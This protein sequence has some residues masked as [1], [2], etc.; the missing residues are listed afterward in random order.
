LT[1]DGGLESNSVAAVAINV[2]AV[3]P[4][5]FGHVR[6][7]PSNK[8]MPLA[9]VVNYAPGGGNV[10]NGVIV[11]MCDQVEVMP[12]PCQAGDV[13]FRSEVSNVHLVVDVTG[14]FVKPATLGASRYGLTGI[15]EFTCVNN[16]AGVRYGLSHR[17][18]R[19]DTAALACPAGTRVCLA[20]ERGATQCDTARPDSDVDGLDCAGLKLDYPASAHRG[21]VRNTGSTPRDGMALTEEAQSVAHNLL[22]CV[23]LPVWCCS[24]L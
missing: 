20:S 16:A 15:D 4:D 24:E 18:A 3:G 5:G 7:W 2:V 10:A 21:W 9:S 14:Y 11:P 1:A 6:A 23:N 17:L 8:Q 13:N 12:F 19:W 22:V